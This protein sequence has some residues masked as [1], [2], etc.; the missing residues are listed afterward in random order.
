MLTE[1]TAERLGRDPQDFTI[2]VWS[3]AVIGAAF[4]AFLA[5]GGRGFTDAIDQAFAFLE[6]GLPL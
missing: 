2:Q 3:G 4:A 5:T 6:A 1:A